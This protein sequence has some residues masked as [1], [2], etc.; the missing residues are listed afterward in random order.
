MGAFR[1]GRIAGID[2]NI[3]WSWFAVFALLTWWLAEGFYGPVYEE[4]TTAQAW[5]VAVISTIIFFASVLLHELSHSLMAQRLGLPVHHITLFIFGGVSALAAEPKSAGEEF[6]IAIVGPLTSFAIGGFFVGISL[7]GY[8]ADA[9]GSPVFAMS[10]Y[11]AFI[12]IAVG[13]FN[14]L[15]GFPLDG[16]RVLRAALWSRSN[17][18]LKAT[19]WAS[20]AGSALS[21]GLISLGV[22]AILV[23]NLIGG[24]WFIVIGWFLRNAS[25]SSYQ[26]QLFRSTLEGAKVREMVNQSHADAPP[27]ISVQDVVAR[28]ILPRSQRC[29]PVM[30]GSELLG[31]FTMSDLRKLPQEEWAATSVFRVMTPREKLHVV[32]PDDDLTTALEMMVQHDVHQLPVMDGHDFLG[33]ITRA[34]V[35]R[36]VQ[37]RRELSGS[38]VEAGG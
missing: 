32:R 6:K 21:F 4:W 37:V 10:Q 31:L 23:G 38:P 28:Y 13:V 19:R 12:N 36:L 35:M 34:D 1:I 14:L 20:H 30:A 11:L 16:G 24:V 18:L 33:F 7:A 25:E 8:A 5:T 17:N 15:P 26:Q 3:H 27:D 2:I 29:I 9:S 22:L